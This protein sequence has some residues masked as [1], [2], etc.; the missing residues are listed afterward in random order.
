[1]SIITKNVFVRHVTG[2]E[3]NSTV[4][5]VSAGNAMVMSFK[6]QLPVSIFPIHKSFCEKHFLHNLQHGTCLLDCK[7]NEY[8]NIAQDY[9]TFTL[10]AISC[11]TRLADTFVWFGGVLTDSIN[12]TII[13]SFNT[14]INI[15]NSK[16]EMLGR[17][18][19]FVVC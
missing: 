13:C 8:H 4:H 10:F 19:Y 6:Q 3:N 15:W 2:T 9:T 1:M 14:F 7:Y 11:V 16:N 18:H 17:D 12:M 5:Y